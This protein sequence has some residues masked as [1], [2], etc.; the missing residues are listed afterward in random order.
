[1]GFGPVGRERV[2][3]HACISSTGKPFTRIANNREKLAMLKRRAV[4][5]LR[6]GGFTYRE[7]AMV[8]QMNETHVVSMKTKYMEEL[9]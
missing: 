6:E 3:K 4:Y 8:L 2:M 1:M 5:L 7:I 9:L